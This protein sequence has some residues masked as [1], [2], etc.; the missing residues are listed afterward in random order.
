MPLGTTCVCTLCKIE[1]R[2][3][4]DLSLAE[5]TS[6][7]ELLPAWPSLH[8][9]SS[10][11]GLL[12]HLRTSHADTQSD[13]L[14]RE[15]LAARA[16]SPAFIESL[17]VLAFLPMLKELRSRQTHFAFAISRAVKRQMFEWANREGGRN[18]ETNHTTGEDPGALAVD[19][20]F[21]QYAL[22]R[23]FLHRCATK[24][25]LTDAELDLLIQFKLEGG[26]ENGASPSAPYSSNAVR[27]RLKRLLAKLR[28]LAR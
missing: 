2:L 18:G 12:L 11:S 7:R 3:F 8:L 4:S 5:A 20:P 24:G 19:D 16:S 14:L 17:L 26:N 6:F 10:V 28:R 21:E 1:A 9:Y 25:L 27:Q 13:E 15:I 22:L 23:H